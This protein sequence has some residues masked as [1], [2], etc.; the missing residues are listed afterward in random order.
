MI[1]MHFMGLLTIIRNCYVTEV[2]REGK[3]FF[4]VMCIVIW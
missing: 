1:L 2:E 4:P 3:R